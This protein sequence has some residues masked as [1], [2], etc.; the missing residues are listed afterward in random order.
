MAAFGAFVDIGV[1]QT[2]HLG[3]VE[4]LSSRIHARW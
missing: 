4:D 1:H 3:D 2:V